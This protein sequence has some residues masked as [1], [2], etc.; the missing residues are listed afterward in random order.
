MNKRIFL[1]CLIIALAMVLGFWTFT[2]IQAV[3]I[4]MRFGYWFILSGF[5]LFIWCLVR[6]LD[7]V[8]AIL[9]APRRWIGAALFAL[10]AAAFLHVHEKHEVKI[11]A[12]EVVLQLTAKQMH[13][14]RSADV[15]VRGYEH[16]GSF[17]PFQS[18]VDKRPLLFPF[19]VAT[20]HD[21]TGYHVQNVFIVNA[22]ISLGFV[23]LCMLIGSRFGGLHGGISAIL[24]AISLPLLAQSACG[25][26]FDL[27]NATMI[28][29][30]V[31]LGLRYAEK[32]TPERLSAFV[33]S[34][35]MLAQVRYE[36]ALFVLPVGLGVAYMWWRRREI[37]LP[38]AVLCAPFLLV[39]IPL[40]LNVFKLN[41]AAWQLSDVQGAKSPFGFVYFY[42]NIGHALNFMLCCDGSQP[43]SILL[44]LVGIG[45]VGFITLTY[46]KE[47]GSILRGQ[48]VSAMYAAFIVALMLHT[49]FMLCYFWGKW[50]DPIIRR[51]SLPTHILFILAAIYILPRFFY[52]RR[53]WNWAIIVSIAYLLLFTIPSE[54]KHLYSQDGLAARTTSWVEEKLARL[55]E[56]S[57]LGI[58]KT[59]GLSWYLYNKSNVTPLVIA[60]RPEAFYF[61]FKNRTFSHY[62]IVQ[63][64]A[65]DLATG[66]RMLG[67]DE[68]F[69]GALKLELIEER[70]FAPLYL[71][72]F[73]RIIDVD[74]EKLISWAKEMR[75]HPLKEIP[76]ST[77]YSPTDKDQLM[78]WF[79]QLP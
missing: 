41:E 29:V 68:E 39:L 38:W 59:S 8:G 34:G 51:L 49:V 61:H 12:D 76:N 46:V 69:G 1:F 44:A 22:A 5:I 2:P 73:S 30:S 24:L 13:F 64:V 20:M 55:G 4:V 27:L 19:L 28:L 79:R 54:A 70:A 65:P 10:C 52:S 7:D 17:W 48:P 21:L 45:A 26:G 36:S 66:Q 50:D 33:M 77:V 63:R 60:G 32:D 53:G 16:S 62:Y 9:C 56:E 11:V 37:Q 57:A 72:R 67:V 71:V 75:A 43:N 18:Y 47:G 6:S 58:D 25:A 78:L 14:N 35:V 3:G 23:I 15:T 74:E 42:E 31:W 40:Q